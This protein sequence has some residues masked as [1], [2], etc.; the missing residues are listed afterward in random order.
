M[1]GNQALRSILTRTVLL[2]AV[3]LSASGCQRAD[4]SPASPVPRAAQLPEAV[5]AAD[6]AVFAGGCFWGVEAVFRHVRGV[7]SSVSGYAGGRVA[8]PSYEDVSRGDS[9]HAEAVQVVYDPSVVSYGTLL[10][11]FFSVAHDPTELNRQGPDVGTQYRSAIFT[12]TPQQAAAVKAYVAQ[13]EAA[14]TFHQPIVTQVAPLAK[15]WAAE[16]YHQNYLALHPTEPYIV[17]NDLPKLDA[18][19]RQFPALYRADGIASK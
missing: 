10:E 15:F 2:L 18:L 1:T 5:A 6:T 14:H 19:K 13:L 8:N 17:Y 7:S 3:S 12:R 9:G 16:A 11:V 4:A